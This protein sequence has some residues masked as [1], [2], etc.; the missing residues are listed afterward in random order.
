MNVFTVFEIKVTVTTWHLSIQARRLAVSLPKGRPLYFAAVLF[1]LSPNV[2]P[3]L[4]D[5]TRSIAAV[6]T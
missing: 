1:S 3:H 2:Q 5:L 4:A 6:E